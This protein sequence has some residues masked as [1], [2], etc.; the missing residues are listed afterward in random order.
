MAYCLRRHPVI[1]IWCHANLFAERFRL[2]DLFSGMV[3]S[4][5]EEAHAYGF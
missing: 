1:G 5:M 2:H 4:E 3:I